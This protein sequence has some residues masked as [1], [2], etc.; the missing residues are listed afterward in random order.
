MSQIPLV[1][2]ESNLSKIDRLGLAYCRLINYEWDDIL[3]PKPKGFD[4]L[5]RSSPKKIWLKRQ[6]CKTGFV[7]PAMKGIEAMIGEA[8]CSRCWWVFKLGRSEEEWFHWYITER[9]R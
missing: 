1:M 4:D 6:P 3:G 5:P 8:N 2:D 7:R 9:F